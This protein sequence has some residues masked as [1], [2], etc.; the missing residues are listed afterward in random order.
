MGSIYQVV[1]NGC[2]GVLITLDLCNTDEQM[3]AMTVQH[4]K[5]KLAARLPGNAGT[6]M[7][8]IR[9]TFAN[10]GMND[11]QKTL[12]SYGVQHKSQIQMVMRVPGGVQL[13]RR[14]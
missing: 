9:L 3:K 2:N 14:R 6:C 13:K 10:K 11:D 8:T 4:L 1:V 12:V 5:K 7:D